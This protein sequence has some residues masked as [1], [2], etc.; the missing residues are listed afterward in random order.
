MWLY[1]FYNHTLITY[2]TNLSLLIPSLSSIAN[3]V[4]CFNK[5]TKVSLSPKTLIPKSQFHPKFNIIS[6]LF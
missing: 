6:H 4:L 2:V 5:P 1:V 3:H